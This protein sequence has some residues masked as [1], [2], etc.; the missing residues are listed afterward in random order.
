MN[1]TIFQIM[2]YG[3]RTAFFTGC[4]VSARLPLAQASI[5]SANFTSNIFK[6]LNNMFGMMQPTGR[7]A[8]GLTR[9]QGASA[10]GF[11]TFASPLDSIWDYLYWLKS[12]DLKN[13]AD[14]DRFIGAGHYA[15]DPAYYKKVSA[16]AAQLAPSL[17]SPATIL[18]GAFLG[19]AATV[20]TGV[21]VAKA[22][23]K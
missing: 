19:T 2:Y 13:D 5:E 15:T 11:A 9:S 3:L 4:Q 14:L 10:N 22:L 20:T 17:L 21:V 8:A 18:A 1:A 6:S 16:K 12:K 7:A 23:S